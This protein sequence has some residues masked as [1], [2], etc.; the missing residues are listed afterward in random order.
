MEEVGVAIILAIVFGRPILQ[1]VVPSTGSSSTIRFIFGGLQF[2]SG[3]GLY[4]ALYLNGKIWPWAFFV[5]LFGVYNLWVGWQ[6]R[7]S[8]VQ[9]SN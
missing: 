2:V 8:R 6:I 4:L 9:A 5:T 3:L 1:A 7:Q